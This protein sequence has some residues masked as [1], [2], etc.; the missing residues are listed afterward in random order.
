MFNNFIRGKR[1]QAVENGMLVDADA[2][3]R[4]AME[5]DYVGRCP[6]CGHALS[7]SDEV[8][9]SDGVAVGCEYCTKWIS[10]YEI[11]L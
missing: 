2:Y 6:M 1:M 5:P 4:Q 8:C 9:A 11:Y 3:D 10:A 7:S